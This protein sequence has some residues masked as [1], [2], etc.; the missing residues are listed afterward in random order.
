ME[1][2]INQNPEH[3]SLLTTVCIVYAKIRCK[4]IQI[5]NTLSCLSQWNWRIQNCNWVIS[6][7]GRTQ[8]FHYTWTVFVKCVRQKSKLSKFSQF[9]DM[10]HKHGLENSRNEFLWYLILT[11]GHIFFI[12]SHILCQKLDDGSVQPQW[13]EFQ[14]AL[15]T[16][17]CFC[18]VLS[19]C[20]CWIDAC[21]FIRHITYILQ[22]SSGLFPWHRGD[23]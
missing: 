20:G 12:L 7:I 9:S 19:C 13:I 15:L 22:G 10:L 18:Y 8:M 4:E 2:M 21:G 11:D 16:S 1:K 6:K 23:Y 14:L 17:K 3:T 5:V